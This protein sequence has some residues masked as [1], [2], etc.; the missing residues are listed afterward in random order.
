[1]G[2]WD[3]FPDFDRLEGRFS[4]ERSPLVREITENMQIDIDVSR[5]E[6]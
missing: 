5:P 2:Q 6:G 3:P 4:A 1:M